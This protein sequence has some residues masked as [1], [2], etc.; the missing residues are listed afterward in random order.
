MNNSKMIPVNDICTIHRVEASF[1]Q[2]VQASGLVE[3]VTVEE[4]QYI[5]EDDL[6]ELESIVRLYNEMDINL[7]GVE[8]IRHLLQRINTMH[9]EIISLK[10][11][12]DFY[13]EKIES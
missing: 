7:E 10:N 4:Q 1:I 5:L 3:I 11:R 12:L 2:S 9:D 6:K 13:E 8:V